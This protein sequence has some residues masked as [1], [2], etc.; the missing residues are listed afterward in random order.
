MLYTDKNGLSGNNSIRQTMPNGTKT[1]IT[2]IL[3]FLTF[4]N[5]VLFIIPAALC[6]YILSKE[7]D[8]ATQFE[9]DY[10]PGQ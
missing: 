3:V 10:P 8:N 4:I 9:S 5:P 7:N 2:L 6:G 1:A